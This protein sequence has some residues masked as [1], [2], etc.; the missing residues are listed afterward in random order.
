M[1][2]QSEYQL[3]LFPAPEKVEIITPQ[4]VVSNF[5]GSQIWIDG[6]LFV[7]RCCFL[8]EN[9]FL[10]GK[11]Y[12]EIKEVAL[13]SFFYAYC[14][15]ATAEELIGIAQKISFWSSEHSRKS[16]IDSELQFRINKVILPVIK[17]FNIYF[18]R[19]HHGN[20]FNNAEYEIYHF[21]FLPYSEMTI[22]RKK[23]F[24]KE[25][26]LDGRTGITKVKELFHCS[27]C[28]NEY[29]NGFHAQNELHDI[30]F[31]V[32]FHC[33]INS[34]LERCFAW[35]H[36]NSANHYA[37]HDNTFV[38]YDNS[39]C[40]IINTSGKNRQD[41]SCYMRNYVDEVHIGKYELFNHE[42][43]ESIGLLTDFIQDCYLIRS[44]HYEEIC[45]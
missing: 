39:L 45:R 5:S 40:I 21:G 43:G 32:C 24:S 35:T 38:K 10:G 4:V 1:K 34:T 30:N 37:V 26:L 36:L 13:V 22:E 44:P 16:I 19:L 25:I 3:D 27:I 9:Y 18:R 28:E 14:M 2:K 12:Q 8:Q 41:S 15:K 17:L 33:L 23:E 7:C 11:E 31:D 29:S 6:K 20:L 42:T